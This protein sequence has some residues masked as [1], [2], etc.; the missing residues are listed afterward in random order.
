[1]GLVEVYAVYKVQKVLTL[2]QLSSINS[3]QCHSL[4]IQVGPNSDVLSWI[5]TITRDFEHSFLLRGVTLPQALGYTGKGVHHQD[6]EVSVKVDLV[7]ERSHLPR[8]GSSQLNMYT[9][10]HL[11]NTTKPRTCCQ[12][13]QAPRSKG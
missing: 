13:C 12:F 6:Y 9:G 7:V 3:S 10:S 11:S 1:M 5:C 4:Q 8:I 2:S